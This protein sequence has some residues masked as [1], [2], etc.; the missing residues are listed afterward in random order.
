VPDEDLERRIAELLETNKSKK[1]VLQMV[2]E[3]GLSKNFIYNK[4]INIKNKITDE[5][6]N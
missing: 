2:D 1:V 4:V 6:G 5:K 3:T